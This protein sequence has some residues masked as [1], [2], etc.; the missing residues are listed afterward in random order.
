MVLIAA[1]Y[2]ND[3]GSSFDHDYYLQ[4]HIP[5]VKERWGPMG[6]EDVR[7]L[8]GIHAPDGSPATY[9]V[10]ALLTFRSMQDFQQAAE[11]HAQEVLG[12]IP[13]FTSVQP[14]LQVSENLT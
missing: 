2:P 5:L 9:Q 3:P 8:R 11:A 1:L 10:I 13:N 14:V 4:T 6:L 7:L 12:D